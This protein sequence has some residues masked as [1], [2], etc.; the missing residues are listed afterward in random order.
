MSN[1]PH[2]HR[3]DKDLELA[4]GGGGVGG[5][6]FLAGDIY[7]AYKTVEDGQT[8]QEHDRLNKQDAKAMEDQTNVVRG[9][10][11]YFQEQIRTRK[12]MKQD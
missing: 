9:E 1:E 10:S 5:G 12:S 6:L 4:S 7:M 3:Q 11:A 8:L 2:D